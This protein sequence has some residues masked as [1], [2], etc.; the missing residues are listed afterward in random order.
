MAEQTLAGTGI[1]HAEREIQ[2]ASATKPLLFQI[3]KPTAA[4]DHVRQLTHLYTEFN[5]IMALASAEINRLKDRVKVL[6]EKEK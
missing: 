6:E 5:R 1:P 2:R 4:M 3:V